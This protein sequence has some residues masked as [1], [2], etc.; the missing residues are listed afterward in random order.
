VVWS[1]SF[2]PGPCDEIR[3]ARL[4]LS[5]YEDVVKAQQSACYASQVLCFSALNLTYHSTVLTLV[6]IPVVNYGVMRK[7]VEWIRSATA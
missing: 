1:V 3:E 2:L 5:L 7:R 4:P 6:V